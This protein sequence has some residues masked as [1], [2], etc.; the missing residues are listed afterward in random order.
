MRKV[1]V[2][3][4]G[5]A[6]MMAAYAAAKAGNEV[7][8]FEKNEKP[9][10]KLFI[11]GK[12]RC[13]VTNAAKMEEVFNNVISNPKFLYS[14]F[15]AFDN[16]ALMELL[17]GAGCKLK[18]E[19]GLRVFPESDHS[20]DVI[21]GFVRLLRDN[22]VKLLL[23]NEVKG[24]F[25]NTEDECECFSYI[26]VENRGSLKTYKD[27]DA[28]IVATGGMSY[29]LT[30]STGDGFKFAEALGLAI[31]EPRPSLVPF[32]TKEKWV[33]NVAGLSLKNVRLT[34]QS[35]KKVLYS[36]M[37]EMLFTHVGIS[38]PLVLSASCYYSKVKDDDCR[39]YIDLKPALEVDTL[40][41]RL[42][43]EFEENK[44]KAFK[45]AIAS[46]FPSSLIP[47]MIS[48][49]G[50][51]PDK[52]CC[53]ISK[54]E[55]REFVSLIKALPLNVEGT[56]S[57]AE[58]I[59]TQ[60]GI[61]VKEINPATMACKKIAGLYFAGEVLDLDAKTGGFNLQIAWSTGYAAGSS[62]E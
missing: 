7:T 56:G 62:I 46:L 1:C 49:S 26:T 36:E 41:N 12:G 22:N 45:N 8:I 14:S 50:I 6:G 42:I 20:S 47:V 3:G 43:R 25:T 27:F 37:G 39:I 11:T 29:P 18:V 44:N 19:R 48:L 2:I 15:A 28:C 55:R 33:K 4:A 30:G 60:G 13:N 35:G 38:G 17:E 32:V 21:N 24:I 54:N 23:N 51:N 40:D 57:F 5:A 31:K 9:G 16:T 34:M 58:A 53:E 52:K 61:S 59:I 10:K